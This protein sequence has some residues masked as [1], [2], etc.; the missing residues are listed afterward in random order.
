MTVVAND[1]DAGNNGSV[2]YSLRQIPLKDHTPIFSIDSHSGL[3]TTS[4]GNALDREIKPEYK[5]IV[6]AKDN[7]VPQQE[8]K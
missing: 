1:V 5:V 6:V 3:I 8:C 2:S 7:G 4:V